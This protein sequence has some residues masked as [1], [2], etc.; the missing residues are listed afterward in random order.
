MRYSYLNKIAVFSLALAVLLPPLAA[1]AE[2]EITLTLDEAVA[3]AL[4]DNRDILIKTEDI[5]KAK[6]GITGARSALYPSFT[7]SGGWSYTRGYYDKDISQYETQSSFK[8]YLFR[9]GKT[10]SS[11]AENRYKT[12]AS[13]AVLEKTKL[14]IIVDVS[15]SF[16]AY[17]LASE[18]AELNKGILTNT[19]AHLASLK[20]RYQNG[21]VS[22]SEILQVEESLASVKEAWEF[23][24]NQTQ[25]SLILLKNLLFID[26]KVGVKPEGE[27]IYAPKE[28]SYDE[29]FLKAMQQ[30][31]EI[32]QYE[33]QVK[34][35]KEGVKV[36]RADALPSAYASWDYY[37]RSH[38]VVSTI[39][40][41]NWN[42]Y[43]ILG[44]TFEWP[45]F[46][47]WSTRAKVEEAMAELRSSQ[48]GKEKV[49]KDVALDI[50]NA[51]INLKDSISRIR[52]S[53]A[54][55]IYYKDN[56]YVIKEKYRQGIASFLD[57]DDASLSYRISEF[58]RKQSIYDYIVAKINFERA[59]GG[60]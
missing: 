19:E 7:F 28:I 55:I 22:E 41:K 26:E 46:D 54:N 37:S 10:A 24:V 45:V 18:L 33:A 35:N 3:V 42:D 30:R 36:A 40:T 21:E 57:L 5:K 20:E 43:N 34:A 29:S 15:K 2:E 12:E 44:V 60:V 58:N 6:A 9:G 52:T 39:N 11:I 49:I 25:T 4:R 53:D 16:Y 8:Q 14:D 59:S 48:L 23:S 27:F 50:K 13:E 32:R 56:L 47:G 51:Y 31:P 17:L 1:Y 38:A